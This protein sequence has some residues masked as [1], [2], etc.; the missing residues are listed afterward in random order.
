MVG[1]GLNQEPAEESMRKHDFH[2]L[3]ED[4]WMGTEMDVLERSSAQEKHLDYEVT[5]AG[6]WIFQK[7]HPMS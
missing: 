3:V 4:L 7:D 2:G 6:V 1:E 5:A